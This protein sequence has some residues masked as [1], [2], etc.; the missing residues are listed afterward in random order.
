MQVRFWGVRGSVPWATPSAIGH[1]CNTPCIQLTD[2]QTGDTL[3]LDAGSGIVGLGRALN[4]P[5]RDLPILLTHY[6]WD[7]VQGLPFL[8]QLYEPGWTPRIIAPR[9]ESHD[10]EWVETIFRSPFFPVPVDR[11]PN[12]PEVEVIEPGFLTIG[13]FEVSAMVLNHP[14]DSLAYRICGMTG[15]L[16]YATDHEF[17]SPEHD[18]R[19]ADFARGAAAIVLD[20]HFTPDEIKH[21]RGWGHSDWRTAAEFAARTDVGGLWLFHHKPG[22]TDEELVKIK[23]DARRVFAATEAAGEGEALQL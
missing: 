18:E 17:G 12:R 6:H 22:R 4:G 21:Y 8:E 15:D 16:V 5:P 1:G 2:E 10:P 11:L 14:G 9:F 23:H 20:A 3:I 19:L 7:H 13:S